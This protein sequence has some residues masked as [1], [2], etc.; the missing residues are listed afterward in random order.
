MARPDLVILSG[1][2]NRE[3]EPL[4]QRFAHDHHARITMRFLGSVEIMLALESGTSIDADA[5]WPAN[6]LWITLGDHAKLVR[7]TASIMHSPVVIGVKR[8]VA[9]RLQWIGRDVTVADILAAAEA[10]HLRFA[11]TS[12]TQ[13][14][15]GASAY[16][17]FLHALAGSPDVLQLAHLEDPALQAKITR[18]LAQVH[19]SSGSSGWLKDLV[20]ERYA[21]FDA[22]VNYECMII[23]ANRTL[24]A[25][26]DEPLIAISPADGLTIADSPLGYVDK[27][28]PAKESLFRELQDY[29]K[30]SPV[31]HEILALGRRTGTVGL[32]IAAVDRSIF[33]P[34]WGIDPSRVTASVPL[35]AEPVIRR[36]LELYQE[37]GLRKPSA[38]VYCLDFSGSMKNHGDTELKAAMRMLLDLPEARRHLIQ[39]SARDLHI[40]IPFNESPRDVAQTA[41]NNPAELARLL[42]HIQSLNAHGGTDIYAAAVQ[43]LELLRS[44]SDL[45]A[46][47]PAIVIMTDGKS[48]GDIQRLRASVAGRDA[49]IP[50]FAITFGDADDDQVSQ[51]ATLTGARVFDGR[52]S[53]VQAF[54]AAKGYN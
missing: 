33:N 50:I 38:T 4:V 46:F 49:A 43:A 23:E 35:P 48:Q 30:S 36:A 16:L 40:V 7:H 24:V 42:T 6:E 34:E 37:G 9:Q 21:E 18:L 45:A 19:R 22:M 10:G 29:L 13:S 12:A 3:L 54:R 51:V 39:P 20:V 8:S 26:G 25:R 11:M 41:G 47:S 1:S 5:V 31:Q 44:R 52:S 15:S 2:E 28:D 53:L 17:G 14:N 32:D 27:H